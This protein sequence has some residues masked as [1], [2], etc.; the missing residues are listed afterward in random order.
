MTN[1]KK[2]W[3][4]VSV[5]NMNKLILAGCMQ[6]EQTQISVACVWREQTQILLPVSNMNSQWSP[7]CLMSHAAQCPVGCLTTGRSFALCTLTPLDLSVK[8]PCGHD[9][10]VRCCMILLAL[11]F[12]SLSPAEWPGLDYL[13][14]EH[15]A[16]QWNTLALIDVALSPHYMS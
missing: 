8:V 10:F 1:M 3:F 13:C 5:S 12:L 2:L 4:P 11:F 7:L 14:S 15:G 9:L 6:R 16:E